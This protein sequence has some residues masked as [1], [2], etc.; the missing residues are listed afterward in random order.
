METFEE[1]QLRRRLA[2]QRQDQ[3]RNSSVVTDA[4]AAKGG[5]L[6]DRIASAFADETSPLPMAPDSP[7]ASMTVTPSASDMDFDSWAAKRREGRARQ[8]QNRNS[9]V[10]SDGVS[11]KIGRLGSMIAQG[12][13]VQMVPE[14]QRV[15]TDPIGNVDA[16]LQKYVNEPVQGMISGVKDYFSDFEPFNKRDVV[17]RKDRTLDRAASKLDETTRALPMVG[18]YPNMGLGR[19]KSPS[20]VGGLDVQVPESTSV[21]MP[22]GR[23]FTLSDE[24]SPVVAARRAAARGRDPMPEMSS[25]SPGGDGKTPI[26]AVNTSSKKTITAQKNGVKA[27]AQAAATGDDPRKAY[28]DALGSAP[29]AGSAKGDLR[30]AML[31]AGLTMLAGG[32]DSWDAISKGALAGVGAYD[33]S[34]KE[35]EEF[36]ERNFNRKAGK[37]KAGYDIYRDDRADTR[38]DRA[39]ARA[40]RG[41]DR[42]DKSVGLQERGL[43]DASEYRKSALDMQRSELGLRGR[44]LENDERRIS[45]GD[46]ISR[47]QALVDD[48]NSGDPAKAKRAEQTLDR[49]APTRTNAESLARLRA[50]YSSPDY[51][52]ATPAER[53][54]MEQALMG[55]SSGPDWADDLDF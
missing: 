25:Q 37:A 31:T 39:D 21:D 13:A 17:S 14:D 41:E 18:G 48:L 28:L 47:I 29:E 34:K 12:T 42:A 49:I 5:R 16:K 55:V 53:N 6:R 24:Q 51:Q 3:N 2:R 26:P 20:Y 52:M 10:V 23:S 15:V 27:A 1:M 46:R 4:L 11:D 9:S 50:L 22:R 54:K 40:D 8:N 44:A 36:A 43:N 45:A 32:E 19:D 38:A 30:K 35:N 7:D 33:T